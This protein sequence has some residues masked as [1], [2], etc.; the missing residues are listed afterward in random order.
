MT[1][2]IIATDSGGLVATASF[3]LSVNNVA[4]VVSVSGPTSG[5]RYESR[6]VKLSAIDPSTVDTAAGLTFSVSWSDG[7][8]DQTVQPAAGNSD[9]VNVTHTY[10][11]TGTFAVRV[12][13]MDKDGAAGAT[14]VQF[15]TI[16]SAAVVDD[17]LQPGQKLLLIGGTS[18]ADR[19]DVRAVSQKRYR[20]DIRSGAKSDRQMFLGPIGRVVMLAG[21]G[22][23]RVEINNNIRVPVWVYGGEGNDTIHGSEN[24]PNFLLGGEGDDKL[25]GGSLRDILI[26]GAGSDVTYGRGGDDL[27]IGGSTS[28]DADATALNAVQLEWRSDRTYEQRV[29]NLRGAGTGARANG[30]T[31][32]KPTGADKTVFADGGKEQIIGGMGQNCSSN[33][34][35]EK[36]GQPDF[37][38]WSK[39]LVG[40]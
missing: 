31:F 13:A 32:L 23:D 34:V 40:V 8:P 3:T 24:A 20:V 22:N 26:G 27:L 4:P 37:S 19:V 36:L 28:F 17:P 29:A 18:Q 10:T 6:M 2:S 11:G 21:A 38:R 25:S 33:T 39:N 30:N 1:V 16:A 5:V 35:F 14:S 15:I 7:S 9:G 12:T